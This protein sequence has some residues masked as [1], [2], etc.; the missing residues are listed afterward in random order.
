LS[1]VQSY[2]A[3]FGELLMTQIKRDNAGKSRGYGFIR[4]A[5]LEGQCRALNERHMIDARWVSAG[6]VG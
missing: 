1:V 4:Y 6:W 3:K 5:E 2:F